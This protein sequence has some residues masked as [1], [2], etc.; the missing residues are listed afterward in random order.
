MS[1]SQEVLE[2]EFLCF[3]VSAFQGGDRQFLPTKTIHT[4]KGATLWRLKPGELK[5]KKKASMINQD[6][7][8]FA[9]VY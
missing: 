1:P 6:T 9:A 4:K 3:V 7:N 2:G 8:W 5:E